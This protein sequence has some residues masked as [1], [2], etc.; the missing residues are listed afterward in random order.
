MKK[1]LE[2]ER[3]SNLPGHKGKTYGKISKLYY[4]YNRLDKINRD[5]FDMYITSD[6]VC[7][8]TDKETFELLPSSNG[9]HIFVITLDDNRRD[10]YDW[11]NYLL[12][13]ET[14][15]KC[16]II[17]LLEEFK[18]IDIN[19][20]DGTNKPKLVRQSILFLCVSCTGQCMQDHKATT[21]TRTPSQCM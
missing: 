5:P 9:P 3:L 21:Y 17:Q 14:H 8:Q 1:V 6:A 15:L 19:M 7:I 18:A 10:I 4:K 13:N 12:H 11:D 16:N 20:R 2:Q